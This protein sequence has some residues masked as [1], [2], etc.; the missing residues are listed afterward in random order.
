MTFCRVTMR[1]AIPAA[2][3]Y[4]LAASGAQAQQYGT[5]A[6]TPDPSDFVTRSEARLTLLGDPIRFSG[7]D[8]PWLGLRPAADASGALFRPSAYEVKDA[9]ATVEAMGGTAV[10]VGTAAA[11]VGCALCLEP[12]PGRFDEGAFAQIDL[13]L[14]EARD[15]GIKLVLPLAGAG[16][17]CMRPA[18]REPYAGSVCTYVRW[19]HAASATA[20]FTDPAIRADFLAHVAAVLGH[21]N[22]LTGIAYA[23]DPTILAWE[24]CDACAAGIDVAVAAPWVETVGQAVHAHDRHHLYENGAFAGRI[25]P[26]TR[27]GPVPVAALAPPSVDIVGDQI[28]ASSGGAAANPR[29]A[30]ARLAPV[31]A[32]QRVGM[33]DSYGWSPADWTTQADFQAFLD[34]ISRQRDLTVALVAG[35]QGHA[36]RGGYLPAVADFP[37]A[38]AIPA[39][40]FPGAASAGMDAAVVDA[41]ARAVRRLSFEMSDIFQ[42]PAFKNPAPP[43]IISAKNGLVAWRGAA[44][45]RAYSIERSTDPM[46]VGSWALLCDRCVTDSSG[47]WQDKERPKVPAWYR[48]SS[49]NPNNHLATPSP[50]AP[51]R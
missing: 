7:A 31:A 6:A 11:G 19:R 20:F 36:D 4:L 30:A 14:K 26:G 39:L 47:P 49:I 28:F 5:M 51:D 46:S 27:E 2:L 38:P 37:G 45:A 12:T 21:V 9:L 13:M 43:E 35:L 24:N 3:L 16:G 18:A 1:R 48:I 42:T 17:D 10:R 8:L 40:Y 29:E 33:I 41:R 44:G 22:A 34:A 15:L 50:A 32:A 25:A 23:D